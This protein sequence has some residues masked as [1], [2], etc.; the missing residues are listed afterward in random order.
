MNIKVE[1][2]MMKAVTIKQWLKDHTIISNKHNHN[3]NNNDN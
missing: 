1:V 3:N 2:K